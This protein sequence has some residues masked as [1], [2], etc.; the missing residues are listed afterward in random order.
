MLPGYSFTDLVTVHQMLK[1]MKDG[2]HHAAKEYGRF[3]EEFHELQREIESLGDPRRV[4]L[5]AL[6]DEMV[7]DCLAFIEKH[8]KLNEDLDQGGIS[9]KRFGVVY[10]KLAW[11]TE[12]KT[13]LELK[14]RINRHLLFA[15]T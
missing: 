10:K 12:R 8:R 7:R 6:Y 5:G 4:G 9:W 15:T 13:I 14:D 2:V 1:A 11:E 3:V